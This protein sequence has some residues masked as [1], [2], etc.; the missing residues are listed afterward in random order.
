MPRR[1]RFLDQFQKD[2]VY[3]S[4]FDPIASV[5]LSMSGPT[6]PNN[7]R[8]EQMKTP[9]ISFRPSEKDCTDVDL[10]FLQRWCDHNQIPLNRLLGV[11]V[12]ALA[13]QLRGTEHQ[14]AYPVILQVKLPEKMHGRSTYWSGP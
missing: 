3:S 2:A 10:Q 14:T 7:K 5:P 1:M 4:S 11:T 13:K 6:N 8:E 12:K 9:I